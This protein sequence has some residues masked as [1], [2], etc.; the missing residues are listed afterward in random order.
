MSSFG[1]EVARLLRRWCKIKATITARKART[2]TAAPTPIPA[3]APALRPPLLLE[4]GSDELGEEE[5]SL[6]L[7]GLASFVLEA[8]LEAV[9]EPRPL[10]GFP[11]LSLPAVGSAGEEGDADAGF[12][13][14]VWLSPGDAVGFS[15]GLLSSGGG[16]GG[17]GGG[18]AGDELAGGGCLLE[19]GGGAGAVVV[20]LTVVP[21][22]VG[23]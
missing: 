18:G 1:L 19:R 10:A 16:G 14:R 12:V 22:G 11:L 3:L 23:T 4:L 20:S 8:V 5:G 17:G 7:P 6:V 13:V 2:A 21:G 9:P 15:P